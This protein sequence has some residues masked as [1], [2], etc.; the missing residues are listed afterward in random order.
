[1]SLKYNVF[2]NEDGRVVLQLG[3]SNQVSFDPDCAPE[4]VVMGVAALIEHIIGVSM[5]ELVAEVMDKME[6]I[7]VV[8]VGEETVQ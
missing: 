6:T 5:V 2:K 7:E 3:V 8:V 4:D 1:M